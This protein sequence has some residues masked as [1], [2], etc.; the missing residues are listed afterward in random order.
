MSN[1]RD[2]KNA[3]EL[4]GRFNLI[5][6]ADEKLSS[7]D[8][9]WLTKNIEE[10]M[11]KKD[12]ELTALRAEVGRLTKS[13]DRLLF[14]LKNLEDRNIAERIAIAE[15]VRKETMY[16]YDGTDYPVHSSHARMHLNE[17]ADRI[18]EGEVK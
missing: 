2:F 18:E 5:C 13:R 4:I 15:A 9:S 11:D 14:E 3:R 12:A 7:A 17:L 6:D 16:T 8:I 10:M 1:V